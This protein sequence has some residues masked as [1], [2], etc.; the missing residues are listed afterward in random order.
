MEFHNPQ[1]WAA[2]LQRLPATRLMSSAHLVGG[3]P[4][5]RLPVRGRYSSTL[6]L[7]VYRK[8]GFMRRSGAEERCVESTNPHWASVVDYGLNPFSL[9]E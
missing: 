6:R 9:W 4:T 3:G 8:R 5:L 2:C 1:S 7:G